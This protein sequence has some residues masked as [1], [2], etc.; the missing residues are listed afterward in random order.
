MWCPVG[1]THLHQ[2]DESIEIAASQIV[3]WEAGRELVYLDEAEKTFDYNK[4]NEFRRYVIECKMFELFIQVHR[5]N[6][7]AASLSG[8]VVRLSP[9]IVRPV[10]FNHWMVYEEKFAR[11]LGLLYVEIRSGKIDVYGVEKRYLEWNG[12]DGYQSVGKSWQDFA[13]SDF[14]ELN[15]WV[16]CYPDSEVNTSISYFLQLWENFLQHGDDTTPR[17]GRPRVQEFAVQAYKRL[18]PTGHAG[19]SWKEVISKIEATGVNVSS[20]TLQRAL[21]KSEERPGQKPDKNETEH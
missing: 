20:K 2:I 19:L 13:I 18:F 7:F 1:Y 4:S 9:H 3:P 6:A 16:V 14:E 8:K 21:S 17:I 11:R 10:I 12:D 5:Y 15:G